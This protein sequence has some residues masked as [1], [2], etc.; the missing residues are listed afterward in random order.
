MATGPKRGKRRP[1]SKK[2]KQN[3]ALLIPSL[4]AVIAFIFIIFLIAA[5]VL[6]TSVGAVVCMIILAVLFYFISKPNPRRRRRPRSRPKPQE[7]EPQFYTALPSTLGLSEIPEEIPTPQVKLPPRPIRAARRRRD[8]VTYPLAVGGGDYSDSYMQA[9]KD[10]IL[11]LRSEMTPDT[12]SLKLPGI[13]IDKFPSSKIASVMSKEVESNISQIA[14]P[15]SDAVVEPVVAIPVGDGV[16]EP[17]VAIPVGDAVVAAVAIPVGDEV[18]GT[19]SI[20]EEAV[21]T[22]VVQPV[23][24]E[25][26]EEMDFDM[27]WD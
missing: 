13:R 12:L 27:E 5:G 19:S 9:D 4:G 18:T 26:E 22:P 24:V 11:R 3:N 20:G 17:V 23:S 8:F 25:E 14:V 21:A 1:R 6:S 2:S 10:T 15:V 16:V 7:K